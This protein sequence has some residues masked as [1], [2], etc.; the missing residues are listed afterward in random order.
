ML[1]HPKALVSGA[2]DWIWP[3]RSL[4]SSALVDRPG[5][6]EGPLWARLRFLDAPR[7]F[8][9]GLPFETPEAEGARCP[10]C[11][12]EAPDF[13]RARAALL[14]DDLSRTLVLDLKRAGRRD[15]LKAFAAWMA[16]AGAEVLRETD[17]L[18]PTPLHWSKLAQRRFNQAAW[19]A[20]ALAAQAQKPCDLFALER[21]RRRKSQEGLSAA[22][23]RRNVAGAFV[24]G[25]G[26]SA[27]IKGRA[28][29][30]IDDVF[31]TGAT[32]QAC[33]RALL[34]AGAA[35]VDVITLA[36]VVRPNSLS[37]IA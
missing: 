27:R 10:T 5:V 3:P 14:Y 7:C 6:I 16:R 9:C 22:L 26:A 28:V 30:V 12:A 24:V 37:P 2:V 32:V 11:L 21:R 4:L 31:T 29:T 18:V 19:L 34:R 15:G 25:T 20:Q 33:A 23:R 8:C 36:R 35:R 13:S 17:V 1:W